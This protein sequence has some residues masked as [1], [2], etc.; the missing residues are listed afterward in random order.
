ME[1]K[2]TERGFDL[3]EFQDSNG[4]ECNMK[5]SSACAEEMLLWV[6]IADDTVQTLEPGKGWREVDLTA[7]IGPDTIVIN[8]MH[9]TQS[10]VKAML[11]HLEKFAKT[12]EL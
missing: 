7:E 6:G 1:I 11:P 3:V 12:G 4:R 8:R 2:Q 5:I 9:L 10:M